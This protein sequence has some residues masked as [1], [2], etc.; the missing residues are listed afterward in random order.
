MEN[1]NQH[2]APFKSL[3]KD[4]VKYYKDTLKYT[5]ADQFGNR[6][7]FRHTEPHCIKTSLLELLKNPTREDKT[8]SADVDKG[9]LTYLLQVHDNYFIVYEFAVNLYGQIGKKM[10]FVVMPALDTLIDFL[11]KLHGCDGDY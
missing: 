10:S 5:F 2:V 3:F 9:D 6:I 1:W 4:E 8:A 7:D 11:E